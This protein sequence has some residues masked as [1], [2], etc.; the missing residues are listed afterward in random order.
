[1]SSKIA[2]AIIHGICVGTEF[3]EVESYKFTSGMAQALK[4][5]VADIAGQSGSE[6]QKIEWADSK[7][8]ISA[9]NWTPV[10]RDERKNLYERLGVNQLDSFFGLREFVFQAIA[11]SL[12]YQVTHSKME[13]LWGYDGIHRCFA[14]SLNSLAQEEQAGK[15]A[16][17]CII[18]H[19]LGTVIA[20]NYIYDMQTQKSQID[21]GDTPLERGETLTSVYTLASQIPFWSLRHSNFDHPIQVPSEKLDRHHPDLKGEWINFFNKSDILGYP[22]RSLNEAYSNAVTKDREVNDGGLLESW[23]PLSHCSYWTSESVIKTIAAGLHK[24]WQQLES[25]SDGC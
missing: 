6:D 5:K 12:T 23:N 2:V 21:I 25:Y 22:L 4:L 3:D 19:S 8:A 13:D 10:L 16:P 7:L 9:I 20:S 17:L 14:E 18:A 15:D 11:D 1:M 24:I